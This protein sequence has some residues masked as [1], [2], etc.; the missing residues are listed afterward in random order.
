MH[1]PVCSHNN[2]DQRSGLPYKTGFFQGIL[3]NATKTVSITGVEQGAGGINEI[4]SQ[5]IIVGAKDLFAQYYWGLIGG[6]GVNYNLGNV[7]LNLD[8][9]YRYG[10]SLVT[11]V[12]NRYSNEQ[13]AGVG[14]AMDDL[15]MDNL[16]IA[17][18]CLFPMR[19]LQSGFKSLDRK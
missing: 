15:N 1:S 7:R 19:F 4:K 2:I 5:P 14:D 8:V 11:S 16:A 3:L 12:E 10:M 17:V 18:G 6:A 9:Q 13:L